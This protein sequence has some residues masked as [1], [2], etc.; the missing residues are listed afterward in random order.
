MKMDLKCFGREIPA[1]G[2]TPK[3]KRA[4]LYPFA[5][6]VPGTFFVVKCVEGKPTSRAVAELR[7]QRQIQLGY[8]IGMRTLPSGDYVLF[9]E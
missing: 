4:T 9:R 3:G 1:V 5:Q 6:L 8:S 7:R 2:F